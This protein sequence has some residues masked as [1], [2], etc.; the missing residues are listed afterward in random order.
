VRSLVTD[1]QDSVRRSAVAAFAAEEDSTMSD[2]GDWGANFSGTT[3][4]AYE[5][6]LVGPM[7][8]P[9]GEHLLDR[10]GVHEGESL[11]DVACGPGTV[12]RLAADRVGH[13]GSVVG[14]DQSGE[15]LSI[16]RAKG[17]VGV[18]SILAANLWRP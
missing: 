5:N 7:F 13:S 14:C 16:A 6:E 2:A 11:L 9:W 10:V 12:A 8:V 17:A 4:A 18:P 3:M 15:M 1:V